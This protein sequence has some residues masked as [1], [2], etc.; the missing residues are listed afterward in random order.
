[1]N[2]PF[3]EIGNPVLKGR[4][5]LILPIVVLWALAF[6]VIAV[7]FWSSEG[8]TESLGDYYLLP[9]AMLTAVVLLAPSAYLYSKGRFEP[10]HPL[11]YGVWSYLFPTFV[12]GALVLTFNLTD[13]YFL[14]YI[15]NPSYNLPLSLVYVC[16]GFIGLVVGYFLPVGR[17]VSEKIESFMPKKKWGTTDVW[18][19]GMFLI[20]AGI[21]LNILGF[22]QGL[23]G[24]QRVDEIGLFDGLLVFLTSIFTLGYVLLWLGVFH[25]K[26]GTMISYAVVALLLALIPLRMA[27]QGNRSSLM[28]SIIPIGLAYWYSG[29]RIKWSHGILFGTLVF[30][31]LAIGIVYGTTFRNIK[32]SEARMSAGDYA[33]QVAATVEYLSRTDTVLVIEQAGQAFAERIE[34]LSSLAVVVSNYEKL[35]SY[36]ESYGIKNNIINEFLTAFIPRFVW[37]EKP[38]VSD[39]RSYSELYFNFGEN[40]FAITVFGDLVRNFGPIGIPFGMMLLGI[41]L[42]IIYDLLILSPEP[43]LW[44]KAAYFPLLVMVHYEGFYSSIFPNAIRVLTI[45]VVGLF[46]ANFLTRRSGVR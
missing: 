25:L 1:M 5:E 37:P 7:Y 27:L 19:P 3:E 44:K 40:S 29:R 38:M 12:G 41:F 36:E 35:E 28:V 23:L 6:V 22:L 14:S 2:R 26:R 8:I 13:P 34:N 9:W 20:S 30:L 18:L 24:Y 16:I 45:V 33:G 32:G 31:A 17:L 21:G 11:V 15:D 42:R 10:F 43:R 39:A 46:V 4:N